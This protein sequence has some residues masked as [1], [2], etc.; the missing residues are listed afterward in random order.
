MARGNGEGTVYDTVQKTKKEFD[1]SKMCKICRECID[2]TACNDRQGWLK[3]NKCKECKGDKDCDR[4]YIYK[5]TFAQIST[6]A[7]RKTLGN[8]KNKKEATQKKIEKQ[9]ELDK[10]KNI[11]NGNCTLL[12]TMTKN[13][14]E[15]HELGLISD[16]TYI[17]H[18]ETIK[19]VAKH[20]YSNKTM[21]NLSEEDV[22]EIIS[23]F[24]KQNASQ[25]QLEKIYDQI[26]GAFNYCHL[27]TIKEIK[28]NTFVSNIEPKDVTAFTIEEEKKLLNYINEHEDTLVNEN[29]SKIDS[30]TVKNLIKFNL[31]TACR[32]G[33]IC[34]LDKD[35]DIDRQNKRVIVHTTLTKNK[36]GIIIIGNQTKTGRK[37]KKAKKKD[38]R[39]IPFG[40]LFDENDFIAMLDEQYEISSANPNNTLNLLFCTKDGKLITHNMFNSIFKR[41]CRQAQIKLDLAEGCNNHMMKH[42]GVTR[43]IEY[44]IRIEVISTVVGTSVEVLRKTYAHILD[45]FIQKEIEKSIL[46]RN[47]NLSLK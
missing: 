12:E 45:D 37:S 14:E 22:K 10:L 26:N 19:S 36:D 29:K 5:R 25:S 40:V 3:C 21:I 39:F 2:R 27:N 44:D 46:K 28:R 7:G 8:G 24:V 18:T 47:K 43:M 4:F 17:R 34:A 38:C 33:E 41:I 11:K 31:A 16:N 32:I 1:N 23:L 15:K 42:T 20:P 13:I 30:K 6:N 9:E 35:E